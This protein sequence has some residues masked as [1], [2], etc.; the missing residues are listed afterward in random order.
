MAAYKVEEVA[1]NFRVSLVTQ[2][3]GDKCGSSNIDDYFIREFLPARLSDQDLRCLRNLGGPQEQHGS[4]SHEVLRRGEQVL[5]EDFM[6]IKHNFKGKLDN[7]QPS[8]TDWIELPAGVNAEDDPTSNI[9]NGHLGIT[10]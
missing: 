8:E 10:W 6:T 3:T 4:A 2:V 5:L 7:G 1:P 9:M